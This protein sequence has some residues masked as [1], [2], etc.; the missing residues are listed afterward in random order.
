M[1]E[2]A[3]IT[4]GAERIEGRII[5]GAPIGVGIQRRALP[6]HAKRVDGGHLLS[7]F[8]VRTTWSA[9]SERADQRLYIH[10]DP[11]QCCLKQLFPALYHHGVMN[12][13]F[14]AVEPIEHKPIVVD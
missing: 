4:T 10:A 9:F 8:Q 13:L 11:A 7:V 3:E 6:E 1:R 12:Y 2:Q 14:Y 5:D